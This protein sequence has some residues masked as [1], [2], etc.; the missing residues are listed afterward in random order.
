M[1]F[2]LTESIP[3]TEGVLQVEQLSPLLFSLFISDME[4][5]FRQHNCNGVSLNHLVEILI[6]LYVDDLILLANSAADL[7][8]KLEVLH[9][10]CNLNGLRVNIKKTKVIIFRSGGRLP[11]FVHFYY[12][13][14]RLEIVKSYIYLGVCFSSPGLFRLAAN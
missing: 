2:G 1:S 6:L 8:R 5:F 7:N 14:N 10:Y 3:V 4:E 11:K 12:D 9:M 13:K